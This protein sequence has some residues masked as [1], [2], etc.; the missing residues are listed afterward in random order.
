MKTVVLK[1][2][3]ITFLCFCGGGSIF[4]TVQYSIK[5]GD[6]NLLLDDLLSVIFVSFCASAMLTFVNKFRIYVN[7][8]G[9][10]KG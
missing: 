7:M 3:F 1:S 2:W 4:Y 9:E 5:E 8:E 6:T 10:I